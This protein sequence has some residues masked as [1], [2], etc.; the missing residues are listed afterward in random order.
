MLTA[1]HGG[2][3][4]LYRGTLSSCNYACDYCPFAKKQDSRAVL[5]RDAREV[6]RFTSW[7][8]TQSRPVSVLVITHYF[9]VPDSIRFGCRQAGACRAR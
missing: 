8:S 2:L 1:H 9:H 7:V 5:A 6:G 4:L 3:S